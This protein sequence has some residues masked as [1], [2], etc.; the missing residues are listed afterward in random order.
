MS[1]MSNGQGGMGHNATWGDDSHG[2]AGLVGVGTR[3]VRNS[4]RNA[5]RASGMIPKHASEGVLMRAA[6][7]NFMKSKHR[8]G[9]VSR[10]NA[11]YDLLRTKKGSK[12]NL[13]SLNR[14]GSQ[15]KLTREGSAGTLFPA[16]R[17]S[18]GATKYRIG[19]G[20]ASMSVP[21][22]RKSS[23]YGTSLSPSNQQNAM[24]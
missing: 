22:M 10:E 8:V 6:G 5:Y 13:M 14:Q 3:M 4:S 12:T 21:H 20:V 2:R 9:S 19:G 7:S 24:W 15:T 16:K 23:H 17:R 1:I 18:T 11:M